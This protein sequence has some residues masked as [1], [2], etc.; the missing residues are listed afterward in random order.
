M[1]IRFVYYSIISDYF[2]QRVYVPGHPTFGIKLN[3]ATV[4]FIDFVVTSMRHVSYLSDNHTAVL[5]DDGL[6]DAACRTVLD[7]RQTSGKP[8]DTVVIENSLGTDEGLAAY[9]NA[10]Q[11]II[12]MQ[13]DMENTFQMLAHWFPWLKIDVVDYTSKSNAHDYDVNEVIKPELIRAIA[14]ANKCDIVLYRRVRQ[15]FLEQLEYLKRSNNLKRVV[16]PQSMEQS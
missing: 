4:E 11:C 8:I 16:M 1:N 10:R 2:S 6:S 9:E 12:G 7:S 5:T 14:E 15:Q 13:D 3:D